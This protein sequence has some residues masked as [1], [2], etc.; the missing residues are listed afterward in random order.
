MSDVPEADAME[1]AQE[2]DHGDVVDI[3]DLDPEV[4]EADAL[5]QAIEIR[6]DHEQS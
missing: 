2:V 5:D 4:P 3:P 6:P 1:Q